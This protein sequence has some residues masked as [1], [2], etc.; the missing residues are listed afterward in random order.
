MENNKIKSLSALLTNLKTLEN[1]AES[2][3][4]DLYERLQTIKS[5]SGKRCA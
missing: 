3:K 4:K 1:P 5:I 2:T